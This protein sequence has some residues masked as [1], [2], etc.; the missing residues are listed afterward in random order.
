MATIE[1][2]TPTCEELLGNATRLQPLLRE[3]APYGDTHRRAADEVIDGLRAAGMFRLLTPNRFG[4]HQT[5][6]RTL[7]HVTEQLGVADASAAWLVGLAATGAWVVGAHGSAQAQEDVFGADPD[8][9]VAGVGDPGNGRRVRDGLLISG[10]WPYA[11]G[12]VHASWAG[13][14][15]M[16]TGTNGEPD[17]GYLCLVPA[18][19][20]T[21]EDT[22]HTVGMR[23]T[24][25]NT[26][27]AE[28]LLV[29]EHRLIPMSS[30]AD[31]TLPKPTAGHLPR[32]P[33]ALA[34]LMGLTGPV[35]G[36]ARAAL[37]LT[38]R[39]APTRGVH[40][41]IFSRRSESVGVQVQ[42]GEAALKL[43]TA[44]LHVHGVAAELSRRPQSARYHDYQYRAQARAEVGYAV[45]Q[46]L[47][48]MNILLNVHGAGSFA[49][50]SE[51]A[52]VFRDVSTAARHAAFN[53]TVGYEVFGKTL[54]GQ[55]ER[56]CPVL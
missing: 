4:G 44:T 6:M 50:P 23:G 48:A 16:V 7:V 42:I 49:E 33:F 3:L 18:S 19:D 38:V 39:A 52:R 40:H 34:G 47:D 36:A 2:A 8:A 27:L 45:A 55:P 12:S 35:L 25:S 41:T 21:L 31:D 56:I 15:A 32:L 37:D 1:C 24:G 9:R 28:D 11:S 46:V 26:W 30:L 14:A 51:M 29:P 53:P 13:L 10:R 17:A 5:D 22:W 43:R 54:L 20:L